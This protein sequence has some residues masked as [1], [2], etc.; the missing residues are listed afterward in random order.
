MAGGTSNIGTKPNDS[1]EGSGSASDNG[2][3]NHDS[4]EGAM[5]EVYK[6]PQAKKSWTM[7]CSTLGEKCICKGT[8]LD[9]GNF[10]PIDDNKYFKNSY[11][12]RYNNYCVMTC[13]GELDEKGTVCGK[14]FCDNKNGTDAV[15]KNEYYKVS[16]S[17]KVWLCPQADKIDT[18]A[19]DVRKRCNRGFCHRCYMVLVKNQPEKKHTDVPRLRSRK[20]RSGNK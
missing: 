9:P 8:D 2:S 10:K 19:H 13:S 12:E 4:D 7:G 14:I 18:T 1:G 11:Y 6:A 15:T 17:N 16:A 3:D 5:K 20:G